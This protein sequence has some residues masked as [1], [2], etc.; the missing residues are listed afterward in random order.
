MIK[1]NKVII[2]IRTWGSALGQE[3]SSRTQK[4][5][6]SIIQVALTPLVNLLALSTDQGQILACEYSPLSSLLAASNVFLNRLQ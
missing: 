2:S 6:F 4:V 1:G 5:Y 3:L